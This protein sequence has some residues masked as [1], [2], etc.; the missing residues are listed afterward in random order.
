MGSG[1]VPGEFAWWRPHDR[2]SRRARILFVL[3]AGVLAAY[4]AAGA[5]ILVVCL[6]AAEVGPW[7]QIESAA[8]RLG[9]AGLTILAIAVHALVATAIAGLGW[10]GLSRTTRRLAGARPPVIDEGIHARAALETFA[11]ARG[12]P[13]PRVWII[14]D[15]AP[16]S[17]VFGRPRSGNVCPTTGALHLPRDELDALCANNVTALTSRTFA[18]ATAAADLLLFA[19]WSTA[20]VWGT[21]ALVL[22]SSLVGLPPEVAAAS[23]L[24]IM[25][26]VAATWPILAVADRELPHLL[27]DA[28]ALVDLETVRISA[29]PSSLAHLLLHLV[30]DTRRVASRWEI[31]HLWFERDVVEIC[32]RAGDRT[33]ALGPIS[34]DRP[35]LAQRCGRAAGRGLIERAEIAVELANGDRELR[36]RLERAA[37]RTL[38]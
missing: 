37:E 22:L 11:L 2:A 26:L 28:A 27:D 19:E 3:A 18:F 1:E 25:L 16:N 36:E 13:A 9:P 5:V 12:I 24:G 31:V 10:M 7:R 20:L 17:L 38:R 8:D 32:G 23:V 14:D 6:R 35:H 21:A 4:L 33:I 30:E 34:I 29:R 15:H